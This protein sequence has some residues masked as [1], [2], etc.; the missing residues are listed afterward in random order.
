MLARLRL[1]A[2]TILATC[3]LAAGVSVVSTTQAGASP[4]LNQDQTLTTGQIL[5]SPNGQYFAILQSDGNFVVYRNGPAPT[6]LWATGTKDGTLLVAQD[7]G[8]LVLYAGAPGSYHP[9]WSTATTSL[10]SIYLVMQDDGNLV[11]YNPSQ[12]LWSS[13]NGR[14]PI[15]SIGIGVN[16]PMYSPSGDY[17]ALLQGDGNFVVY[18]IMATPSAIWASGTN[19]T[20]ASALVI[21]GDGNTVLYAGSHPVWAT[22]TSSP[23]VTWLAMQDDGNL[24]LY[25]AGNRPLWSTGTDIGAEVVVEASAQIGYAATPLGS[26]CNFFTAW[27]ERGSD[28]GCA[29]GTRSEEW[30]SD[31]ANWVWLVAGAGVTRLTARSYTF[32]DYGIAH[33]T[34]KQGPTN[35]PQPGDAV[36]WGDLGSQYGTHVGIVAAVKNGQ[37]NVISGNDG[38]DHVSLSGFFNP[39]TSTISGY[40]IVGYTSPLPDAV[41]AARGG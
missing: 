8:N 30:C 10:S 21:Q 25:T 39:A 28:A 32:V 1:Y 33:G 20:G 17:M 5:A 18:R 3:L 7:D 13:M 37:I 40:S 19:G 16:Q 31:F 38:S 11:L 27:F 23:A 29:P 15:A 4:V 2:A 14:E 26:K 41:A 36:V 24:V 22:A 9:V 35:N 34:F 6:P 12:A